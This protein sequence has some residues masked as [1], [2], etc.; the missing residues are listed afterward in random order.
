MQTQTQTLSKVAY[1][2]NLFD[3]IEAQMK[4]LATIKWEQKKE[5]VLSETR[6]KIYWHHR[7]EELY[8]SFKEVCGRLRVLDTITKE[9][10]KLRKTV[11]DENITAIEGQMR[12]KKLIAELFEHL[13]YSEDDAWLNTYLETGDI[14]GLRRHMAQPHIVR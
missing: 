4:K 7:Y 2:I 8:V 1:T 13:G 3:S 14:D 12:M 9:L 6:W 11:K 10:E 5:E